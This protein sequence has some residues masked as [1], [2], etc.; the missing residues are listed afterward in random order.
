[1]SHFEVTPAESTA[2]RIVFGMWSDP[3]TGRP[4]FSITRG[5][6]GAQHNSLRFR[7]SPYMAVPFALVED[8]LLSLGQ[9]ITDEIIIRFGLQEDLEAR[10]HTDGPQPPRG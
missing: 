6:E 1:M 9:A 8:L 2:Y 3:E 5:L 10:W 4:C 7:L